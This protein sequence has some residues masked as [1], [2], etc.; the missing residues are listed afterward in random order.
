MHVCTDRSRPDGLDGVG[1]T[2]EAV[3]DQHQHVVQAA[4]LQLSEHVQPVLRALAAVTGPDPEDVAMPLGCHGHHDVDR[5]VGDLAVTDL[6]VDGVHEQDWIHAVQR[7]AGPFRHPLHHL[8]GNGGDGLLGDLRTVDLGQVGGD[9]TVGEALRR[10]R[11]HH[12]VHAGQPALPLLHDLRLERARHIPGHLHL[13][14]ANV[15]QHGLR[16]GP[17]AAVAAVPALGIVLL[18]A[19][20]IGDLALQGRLQHPLGQH[21]QQPALPGQL[22]PLGPGP[23]HEHRNQLLVRRG[24]DGLRHRLPSGL[25]LNG[26]VR[27]QASP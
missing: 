3:A 12:L 26:S 19:E 8:V 2:L 11:Q 25:E 9:L 6:D 27:H 18:V 10:Q 16:P 24:R 1:E 20:V 17:V 21:L 23:V 13:D 22:Q 15:G 4:V 7:A 5:P 14:R